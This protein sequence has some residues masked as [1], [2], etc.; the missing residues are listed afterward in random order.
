MTKLEELLSL[1]QGV[2]PTGDNQWEAI[3]PAHEDFV[4]SLSVSVRDDGAPL[5]HCFAGCGH[6]QICHAIGKPTAWL[7]PDHG[8]PESYRSSKSGRPKGKGQLVASFDYHDEYGALLYQAC[9]YEDFSEGKRTKTFTQ[10]RPNGEGGWIYNMTGVRKVPYRLQEL[11]K[12]HKSEYVYIPEGEKHCDALAKWGL[13]ATCNIGGASKPKDRKWLKEYNHWFSGRN[14][15]LLPDNDDP[16]KVHAAN[17]AENL[18]GIAASVIALELPGLPP[19]GDV[20]D[21]IAAGGT[22]A[23]FKSLTSLA[24]IAG[25]PIEAPPP[26]AGATEET[27]AKILERLGID[28]FGEDDR[29]QVW[30]YSEGFRKTSPIKDVNRLSYVQLLQICGPGTRKIVYNGTD[31]TPADMVRLSDVKQAIALVAGRERFDEF[32]DLGPGVWEGRSDGETRD[33]V[34]LVGAGQAAVLNGSSGVEQYLKPRYGKQILDLG[35]S[36]NWFDFDELNDRITNYTPEWAAGTLED[37]ELV[38]DGWWFGDKNQ[39][40][41]PS[42]LSGLVLATWIQSMWRWRPQVFILGKSNSGKST[43]FEFLA[44]EQHSLGIFGNLIISSGDAT[45]AGISQTVRNSSKAIIL[46]EL[47]NSKKRSGVFELLR[48]AGRGQQRLRGTTQ[49]KASAAGIQHIVWA[50]A[51]ESGLKKE[52]DRNRF[53]IVNL[54]TPPQEKMGLLRLPAEDVMVDLGQ[55]LL[56]VAVKTAFRAVELSQVLKDKRPAGYHYRVCESYSVPAAAYA[57]AMGMDEAQAVKLLEEFLGTTDPSEIEGDEHRLLSAIMQY[58]IP[59]KGGERY[60]V[61]QALWRRTDPDVDWALESHGIHVLSPGKSDEKWIDGEERCV[62]LHCEAI[63]T[64][65]LKHDIEWSG[66]NCGEIL[67]RLEKSVECRKYVN[68]GRPRGILLPY[69][70][71]VEPEK[72]GY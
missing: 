61:A 11:I 6:V 23:E 40:I 32:A 66:V 12:S 15:V 5:V 21:W 13:I 9:R 47:E 30:V 35:N 31:S 60:S 37:L 57:A 62:F 64:S 7:F 44:G 53:I 48:N 43:M 45:A 25:L 17:V 59:V 27:D 22:E 16:G 1:L 55:R 63:T 46:D 51:T 50:A 19:K 10:R 20:L 58:I 69:S 24:I 56:A 34:V 26:P 67:K 71:I 38:F 18:K 49:Q 42:L 52:V 72:A 33:S 68:G 70:M 36:D 28:V 8:L 4:A 14:V 41:M 29:G 65:I 2:R 54:L 3:C 39:A